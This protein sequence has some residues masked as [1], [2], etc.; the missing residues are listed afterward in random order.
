M[1]KDST[2]KKSKNNGFMRGD[3]AERSDSEEENLGG[4]VNFQQRN[5]RDDYMVD[6]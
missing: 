2:S 6:G 5:R 4:T 1:K 3:S